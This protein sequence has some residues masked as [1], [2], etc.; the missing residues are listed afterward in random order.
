[1]CMEVTEPMQASLSCPSFLVKWNPSAHSFLGWLLFLY[2][3]HFPYN[4]TSSSRQGWEGW[5]APSPHLEPSF[6]FLFACFL[7]VFSIL[8][9]GLALCPFSSTDGSLRE[10]SRW[11]GDQ[12]RGL[13]ALNVQHGP[14][15]ISLSGRGDFLTN[16]LHY[17]ETQHWDWL[18][19]WNESITICFTIGFLTLLLSSSSCNTFWS[20]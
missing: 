1:M 16:R 14:F 2:F 8:P 17:K 11:G 18:F 10:V 19:F 4:L 15:C 7:A 12:G 3:L 13:A 5:A 9:S 20:V 6:H